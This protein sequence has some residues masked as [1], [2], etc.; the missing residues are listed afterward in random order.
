M[1]VIQRLRTARD[2]RLNFTDDDLVP[3][4]TIKRVLQFNPYNG[5]SPE[6]T[7]LFENELQPRRFSWQLVP[8]CYLKDRLRLFNLLDE[9]GHCLCGRDITTASAR[10][11]LEHLLECERRRGGECSE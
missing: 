9:R 8:A 4:S 7:L 6:E 1:S 3:F 5:L 11:M 2:T 10:E